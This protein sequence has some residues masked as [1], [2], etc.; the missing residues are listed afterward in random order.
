MHAKHQR[1]VRR[2]S[3]GWLGAMA[4]GACYPRSG[5]PPSAPAPESVAWASAK[6]PGSGEDELAAGRKTLLAHCNA[7]HDYPALDAVSDDEW[8]KVVHRMSGKIGL[9]AD[10]EK[11]V[12]HF[13]LASHHH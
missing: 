12:L 4:L 2:V 9:S 1:T 8:P 6:W 7:C 13:V 3:I 10:E 11:S 5:P